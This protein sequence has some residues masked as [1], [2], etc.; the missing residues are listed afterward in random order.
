MR[1][2]VGAVD[3][4]IRVNRPE[5][6]CV[7]NIPTVG[8]FSHSEN[9]YTPF[10]VAH[11]LSFMFFL[12]LLIIN[13]M[14]IVVI[15][16]LLCPGSYFCS[17]CRTSI[18]TNSRAD[19]HFSPY[20]KTIVA[21]IIPSTCRL[22]LFV[23]ARVPTNYGRTTTAAMYVPPPATQR[24]PKRN[25]IVCDVRVKIFNSMAVNY[26]NTSKLFKIVV[27]SRCSTD[28]QIPAKRN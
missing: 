23:W 26:I 8:E 11:S 10:S 4:V 17:H 28:G 14:S 12:S 9:V 21:V 1:S 27:E 18:V 2:R 25:V 19:G 3:F 16:L 13:R 24:I 5:C 15:I 22:F 7:G 6:A 20:S